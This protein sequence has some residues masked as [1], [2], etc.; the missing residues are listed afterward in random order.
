MTLK[1]MYETT[2]IITPELANEDF[3][4]IIEKFNRVLTENQAEIIN[5]EVWG[6][7]KLAYEINRKNSGYYVFTEFN[8]PGTIVETLERE[9]SYDDRLMRYLTV[10]LDKFAAAYNIRRRNKIKEGGFSKSANSSTSLSESNTNEER[11]EN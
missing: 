6:F 11:G 4:N 3:L 2:Y 5:Q 9:Y 10:R 1:N 7:R 8:A